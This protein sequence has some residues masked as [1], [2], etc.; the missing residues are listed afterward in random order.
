MRAFDRAWDLLKELNPAFQDDPTAPQEDFRHYQNMQRMADI[1]TPRG[2]RPQPVFSDEWVKQNPW[3]EEAN[4]ENQSLYS[5]N[6]ADARRFA[7]QAQEVRNRLGPDAVWPE[8]AQPPVAVEN[9]QGTASIP[10]MEEA[11]RILEEA[12]RRARA[13]YSYRRKIKPLSDEEVER[14]LRRLRGFTHGYRG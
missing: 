4:L 14:D 1:Y 9:P 12:A 8:R 13:P 6:P 3:M 7:E 5:R 2:T 11:M 10:G